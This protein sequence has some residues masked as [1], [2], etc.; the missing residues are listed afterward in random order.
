MRESPRILVVDDHSEIRESLVELL[1]RSGRMV[2]PAE[3]AERARKVL[4][5]AEIDLVVLDIM[6]PGEDGLSLCRHIREAREIP[7]IIVSALGEE[8]D[9]IV[10]LEIGADDYLVKP[11]SARELLARI[12]TVLRRTNALPPRR[13][14]AAEQ[15][16]TFDNWILH[17]GARELVSTAGE[18]MP[19]STGEFKLLSVLLD[20][21]RMVLTREQLL[22]HAYGQYAEVLDR[23]IDT[24]ISRLRRKIEIDPKSPK[25][26]KTVWGGGYVFSAE[27][28]RRG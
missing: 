6:L 23:A 9:R 26:I 22:D 5:D 2:W 28:R 1:E 13:R 19:L 7:V 14:V 20:R 27:V 8:V 10:G 17:V 4:N 25:I 3:S 24:H 16:I 21:P 11:F 15:I 12:E 18:V